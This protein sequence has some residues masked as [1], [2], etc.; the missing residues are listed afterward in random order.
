MKKGFQ[1]KN[2][3][4][5]EQTNFQ[6]SK[7]LSFWWN[8]AFVIRPSR[9]WGRTEESADEGRILTKIRKGVS[10]FLI[11]KEGLYLPKIK[12][13]KKKNTHTHTTIKKMKRLSKVQ[14]FC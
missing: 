12:N 11:K 9:K 4:K 13:W 1:K 2:E 10:F 5:S 6:H 3:M 7:P 8:F 14:Q